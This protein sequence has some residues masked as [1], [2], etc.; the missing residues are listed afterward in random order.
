MCE[1]VCVCVCVCV[2]RGS[3][4]GAWCETSKFPNDFLQLKLIWKH[5]EMRT[6]DKEEEN[7]EIEKWRLWI[8]GYL[9]RRR[10]FGPKCTHFRPELKRKGDPKII[11]FLIEA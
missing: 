4:A 11:S 9:K 1:R 6:L 2:G 5:K 7:R 10:S 8:C 3:T